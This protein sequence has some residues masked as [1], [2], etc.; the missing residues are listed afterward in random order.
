LSAAHEKGVVH[1]DLKPDNLFVTPNGHVK[2]LDF[3]IAKLRGE[4]ATP[5]DATRTGALLGT[6]HYM[7]PEQALARQVDA[8][9]D[10]YA[11]GVIAF[12]AATGRR[13]FEADSLFELL[14]LHVERPAPSP[15]ALRP[16][17]PPAY[18]ATI[19]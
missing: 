9:A 6:P 17:M 5:G 3:G 18:E 15:R 1:R 8:R 12:E 2:V 19:V 11:V 14:R 10:L 7:S 16:D 13:P 4:I